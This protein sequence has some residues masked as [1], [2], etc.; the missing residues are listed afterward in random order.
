MVNFTMVPEFSQGERT[1]G[2]AG[3]PMITLWH[4]QYWLITALFKRPLAP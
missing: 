4:N 1:G 2:I 3:S